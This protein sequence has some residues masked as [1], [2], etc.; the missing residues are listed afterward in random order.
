MGR[1]FAVAGL[2]P[3]IPICWSSFY[4]CIVV[5]QLPFKA[6]TKVTIDASISAGAFETSARIGELGLIN[7]RISVFEL[8][9]L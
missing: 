5:A 6:V 8:R 3:T 2:Y 9:Q 1:L 7:F 4:S